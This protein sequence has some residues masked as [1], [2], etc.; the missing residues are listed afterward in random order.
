MSGKA[1]LDVYWGGFLLNGCSPLEAHLNL[2]SHK[3]VYCFANLNNPDRHTKIKQAINLISE[4]WHTDERS[5]FK[6]KTYAAHL[7]REGYAVTL[8]NHVDPLANS[9]WFQALPMIEMLLNMNIPISLMTR[10][11]KPDHTQALFDLISD[12]P[13]AIYSSIP[14]LNPDIARKC[15]PGAPL[16]EQRLE[17]IRKAIAQ[18]HPVNVGINPIIPGWI[19]DPDGMAKLLAEI[20]VWGVCLG[21]LHLSK[22]QLQHMSDR[23]RANL[24]DRA[25]TAAQRPGKSLEMSE[26]YDAVRAACK[27]HG[28]QVYSAQQG[29]RSDFFKHEKT[30]VPR[31]FPLMQD[32]VNY[33]HDTKQ[34]GDLIFCDEWLDFFEPRLPQG[35]WSLRDHLNAMVVPAALNGKNIPQQMTYRELLWHCWRHAET[36]YCPANVD[37]F[38]WAGDRAS[39]KNTWTTIVD[40]AELPILVFRP[41]GTNGQAFTEEHN[42]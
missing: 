25:L 6:R 30:V 1:S 10:F 39:G 40:H 19:D 32:F 20:G 37:C 5:Q 17:Y 31:S 41:S 36:I 18:G 24:G 38:A 12:R 9:N 7:L 33:C 2:C 14:T 8:S 16:P 15:E 35:K 23:E 13:T 26:L 27:A 29:D 22:N 21:K 42:L 4:L 34:E 3:C 11:G 28:L